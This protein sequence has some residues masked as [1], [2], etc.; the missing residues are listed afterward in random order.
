MK[1]V[2]PVRSRCWRVKNLSIF[3]EGVRPPDGGGAK[4]CATLFVEMAFSS[5]LQGYAAGGSADPF[6]TGLPG[7]W[8]GPMGMGRA[9]REKN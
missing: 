2:C 7:Y 1:F 3:P 5:R 8:K 6:E 4:A 9:A